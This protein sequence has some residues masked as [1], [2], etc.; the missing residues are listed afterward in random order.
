MESVGSSSSPRPHDEYPSACDD[1]GHVTIINPRVSRALHDGRLLLLHRS[2]AHT[3]HVLGA[4]SNVYAV[5]ISAAPSCSCPDPTTPCKHI[6]FVLLRVLRLPLTHPALRRRFLH[7]RLL[8]RLLQTPASPA[9]FAGCRARRRFR[10]LFL[11]AAADTGRGPCPVCLEEM[12]GEDGMLTC[13]AC[14]NS[15]H[16]EC[17]ARW[18]G[19]CRGRRA[20][21]SC[22]MCR[23]RWRER[24]ETNRGERYVN[25]AAY[26]GGEE[27]EV[28]PGGGAGDRSS[29]CASPAPG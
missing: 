20:P 21:A 28:E 25:L 18:K 24:R 7:P 3:F 12:A 23:A 26:V 14:G 10:Q 22:V 9:S 16:R 11:A 8:S 1:P 13:G 27:P 17:W 5:T 15:L 29:S 6:L 4:T 19:S 2:G